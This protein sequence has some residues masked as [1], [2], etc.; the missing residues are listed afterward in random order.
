MMNEDYGETQPQFTW[1][2]PVPLEASER[3][4]DEAV[5][6]WR[7]HEGKVRQLLAKARIE[8]RVLATALPT[9]KLRDVIANDQT[10]V[11]RLALQCVIPLHLEFRSAVRLPPAL[12]FLEEK[13]L[14]VDMILGLRNVAGTR[15]E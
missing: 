2:H 8:M 12:N 15:N 6:Y 5:A 7:P 13:H 14:I 3:K 1:M 9:E 4:L 10:A 11:W